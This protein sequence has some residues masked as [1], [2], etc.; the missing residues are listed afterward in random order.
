MFLETVT[1]KLVNVVDPKPEMIDIEDIA[2][3]LSRIPRFAGHTITPIPYS[4]AQHSVFVAKEVNNL[5]IHRTD[6]NLEVQEAIGNLEKSSGFNAY[7]F[8]LQA[9]LHDAAE[10][11]IG[12]IPS[13]VKKHPAI[14]DEIKKIENNLMLC[15]YDAV[16]ISP[17]NSYA[18]FVIKHADLI[19]RAVEAHAFMISRGKNWTGMPP[20][21]LIKLQSF[22]LPWLSV[23]A[24]EKFKDT[25]EEYNFCL[26]Y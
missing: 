4:V 8:L 7:E 2:W 5:L 3:G 24:Y 15:V 16:G 20:V 13:P 12:D 22:E 26:T 25:F 11:Y 23:E 14:A 18:E 6:A 17:P 21:T 9:L 1:G 10:V 19:A